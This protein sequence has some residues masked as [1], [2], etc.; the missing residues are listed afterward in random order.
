MKKSLQLIALLVLPLLLAGCLTPV[1]NEI[2]LA[3]GDLSIQ[4][5]NMNDTKLVIFNDSNFLLYGMDGSGRINV[6]LNG[7]GV[8]Q[9]HIGQ[10]VQVMVPKGTCQVDLLHRDMADLSSQHQ[11]ELRDPESFLEIYST[12]FANSARLVPSLPPDFEKNFK[13]VR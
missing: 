1:K 7:K 13:P 3:G 5:T 2:P 9:L 8:A 11:I 10:Y 4:A 6:R 12:P